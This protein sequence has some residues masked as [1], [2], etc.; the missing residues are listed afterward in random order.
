MGKAGPE[1]ECGGERR[2]LR[3]FGRGGTGGT[4]SPSGW[5]LFDA[6]AATRSL[7]DATSLECADI[8]L[9]ALFLRALVVECLPEVADTDVR[10]V[11]ADMLP[12]SRELVVGVPVYVVDPDE[13]RFGATKLERF[14]GGSFSCE[15]VTWGSSPGSV[16][17]SSTPKPRPRRGPGSDSPPFS[18]AG[19][20][21]L[22]R[23]GGFLLLLL[24][25]PSIPSH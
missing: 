6:S 17:E 15:N 16:D 4:W 11:A 9:P 23:A 7:S 14:F 24:L 25:L 5:S 19:A 18:L 12:E 2:L 3:F 22:S 20:A 8:S 13:P 1:A 21:R 10:L